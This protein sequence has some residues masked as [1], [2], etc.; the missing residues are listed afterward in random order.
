M[1]TEFEKYA[2]GH[3]GISSTSLDKYSRVYAG[4]INPTII[5]ERQLNVATMDVF[6]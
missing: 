6:S 1:A 5:E 2:K 4:Y 3:L